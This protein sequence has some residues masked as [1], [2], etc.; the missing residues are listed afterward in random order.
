MSSTTRSPASTRIPDLL[1]GT[2]AMELVEA[3]A[4]SLRRGRTV[5][6][7]YERVSES[8]NFKSVMTSVGCVLLLLVLVALPVALIGPALGIGWTST[9]PTRSPPS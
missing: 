7:H 6:L 2:R 1:D 4:R 8:G 3:T 5:D 9:S